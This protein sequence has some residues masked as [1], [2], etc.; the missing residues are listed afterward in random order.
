MRS[1]STHYNTIFKLAPQLT[2][3]FFVL[4]KSISANAIDFLFSVLLLNCAIF[5]AVLICHFATRTTNRVSSIGYVAYGSNW[6]N[7]PPKLQKYIILCIVHSQRPV[8]FHGCKLI[9]CTLET[10]A[11]VR[12]TSSHHTF[13]IWINYLFAD[14]QI[15]IFLLL[16]IPQFCR[17]I[18]WTRWIFGPKLCTNMEGLSWFQWRLFRGSN[19]IPYHVPHHN[20]FL[21]FCIFRLFKYFKTLF[22]A[23]CFTSNKYHEAKACRSNTWFRR[24]I[25]K[26]NMEKFTL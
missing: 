18:I 1:L 6:F 14:F 7:Y 13:S 19:F 12:L 23:C 2:V 21:W 16:D 17:I 4:C 5:W 3:S 10:L 25:L 15:I 11:K 9:G 26:I 8:G 20:V 22:V 24:V